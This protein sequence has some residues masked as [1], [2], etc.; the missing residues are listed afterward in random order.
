MK[1]RGIVFVLTLSLLLLTGCAPSSKGALSIEKVRAE[2]A[3]SVN[4]VKIP[5]KVTKQDYREALSSRNINRVRMVELFQP[6]PSSLQKIAEYRLFEIQSKSVFRM[7]GLRN[8]DVLV[9]ADGY[10]VQSPR[11]FYDYVAALSGVEA[12]TIEIRRDKRPLLL[13]IEFDG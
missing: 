8:K 3:E 6:R 11:Q 4:P 13:D 7:L 2:N 1:I 5:V 10:V 9:A 12:A